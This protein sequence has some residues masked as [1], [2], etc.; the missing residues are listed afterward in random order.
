V[1]YSES[2]NLEVEIINSTEGNVKAIVSGKGAGKAFANEPGKHVCQRIPPT[3]QK[4]RKHTSTVS[5]SVL[6]LENNTE[7][8][9][10]DEDVVVEK[11]NLGGPGGQKRNKTMCDVRLTH[12]P[13]GL[14][15]VV[16]GRSYHKNL[17]EALKI[18]SNRVND[19]YL[20]EK[21]QARSEA[22]KGQMGGGSRSDKI[23][24]YNFLNSRVSDHRLGTKTGNI[25]GVMRGRLDLIFKKPSK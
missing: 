19:K 7:I 25:K 18:L 22:R 4:G 23:R 24:T 2:L 9:L 3:E 6:P 14:Q 13:T 5:V 8:Q 21:R 17:A 15:A 1:R 12:K 20:G 11:C 16:S 10:L